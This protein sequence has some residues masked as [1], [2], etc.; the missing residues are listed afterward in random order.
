[1]LIDTGRAALACCGVLRVLGL[2]Q[3]DLWLIRHFVLE[4]LP[5]QV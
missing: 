3:R 5:G 4:D 2:R 1:M